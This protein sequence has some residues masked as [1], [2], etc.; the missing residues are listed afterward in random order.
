MNSCPDP[1]QSPY[2]RSLFRFE[3]SFPVCIPKLPEDF[4]NAV[5]KNR[6]NAG[7][8]SDLSIECRKE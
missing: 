1:D 7:L 8:D 4:L 6:S 5:R 2:L 3:F